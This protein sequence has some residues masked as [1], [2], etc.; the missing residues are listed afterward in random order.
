VTTGTAGG[1]SPALVGMGAGAGS[2]GAMGAEGKAM[3]C[4][5]LGAAMGSVGL[6][7]GLW[8]GTSLPSGGEA[9]LVA[10]GGA[11]SGWFAPAAGQLK[12]DMGPDGAGAGAAI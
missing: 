6:W 7:D 3:F 5:V 10:A 8:G 12:P 4:A 9:A 1:A 11:S 2:L